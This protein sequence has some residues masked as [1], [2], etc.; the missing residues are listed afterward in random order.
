M[1][2]LILAAGRGRRLGA[3]GEDRPKCLLEVGRRPL[4]EHQLEALAEAGVGPVAMVVGY[5]ADEV[6]EAVRIRAEFVTNPRWSVTNSLY[7]FWLARAWIRGPLLVLNCDVLF[8]RRILARLLKA[9]GDAFAYDSTSGQGAEHMKVRLSS[10]GELLAMSKD[11]AADEVHGENV[12]ILKF[13]QESAARLVE[14]AGKLVEAGRE[15]D[16]LGSAVCAVARQQ[17]LRGVDVAG[18][19]WGEIDFSYDLDKVRREVWPAIRDERNPNRAWTAVKWAGA[20]ASLLLT[21]ML[22][23]GGLSVATAESVWNTVSLAGAEVATIAADGRESSWSL[24]TGDDQVSLHV[25]GPTRLRIDSRLIF[26]DGVPDDEQFAYVLDVHMDGER[27][28]YFMEKATPS[29]TWS[30]PEWRISKRSRVTLDVPA[31]AHSVRVGLHA[32]SGP[33]CLLRVRQLEAPEP[34]D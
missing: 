6:R 23:G 25:A 15:G 9:E 4:V 5:G 31:G 12:G 24:V 8:D 13:T 32:S 3:Q 2:A 1:Q 20:A 27:V 10:E 33:G 7:S 26:P 21:G 19:P 29:K 28:D 16:W 18:L 22:L 11:L 30:H 34:E 17:P 14:E